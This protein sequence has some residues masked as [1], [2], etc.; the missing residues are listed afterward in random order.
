MAIIDFT[1][2]DIGAL[3]SRMTGYAVA[4][5]DPR[6]DE[7][8]LAWNL[9]ADQRPA[10]VAFPTG[11]ADVQAI[12]SFARAAGLRVTAQGTGHNATAH[13]DLSESILVKTSQIQGA[14][15]DPAARIARV[16]AGALWQDVVP[17]ASEHGLAALVGSSPDVGIVGYSLGGGVGYL[18]RKHGIA[19]N[20]VTAIELVTGDGEA[21]RVDADHA[22]DLFWALRGGG[23]NFGVV[24]AMEFKLYPAESVY[25][26]MMLWPWERSAELFKRWRDWQAQT[27]DEI[28]SMARMIQFPDLPDVPEPLRLRKMFVF[29]AAY[30]GDHDEG[31]RAVQAMRE[32]KPEI[33]MFGPMPPLGLMRLHGDPEGGIPGA[34]DHSVI[35]ALPD[36]AIDEVVELAGPGSDSPLLI[37]ELRQMGGALGRVPEGAGALE[38]IDGE[39]LA[40]AVGIATT[41]EAKAVIERAARNVMAALAPH[42]RGRTYLNFAERV[43]NARSAYSVETHQRLQAVKARYDSDG[44]LHGNHHIE[45]G[46]S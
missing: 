4:P 44:L 20:S 3:Q 41:P 10:A 29:S 35:D 23:G 39:F 38:K 40:F 11:A 21:I 7:A 12:I 31:A 46:A 27:P 13:G 26:G 2:R 19:T 9:A 8:R 1:A 34:S 37:T 16:G 43:T 5:H 25:A 33:D 30:L 42:S 6:W 18:G 14:S 28:T 36:S 22:P 32:M 45:A 17:M 24:T 15:V